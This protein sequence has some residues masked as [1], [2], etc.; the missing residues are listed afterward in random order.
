M[1]KTYEKSNWI[2]KFKG[3]TRHNTLMVNGHGVYVVVLCYYW[4]VLHY[5]LPLCILHY[6]QF[7]NLMKV[8]KE[9]E[10]RTQTSFACYVPAML[11]LLL[12]RWV[13]VWCGGSKCNN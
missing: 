6:I 10:A 9:R 3:D 5:N 1:K 8:I 7:Q 2:L 11:L 13:V 12:L 4:L